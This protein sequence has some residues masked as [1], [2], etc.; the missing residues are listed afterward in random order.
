MPVVTED[1]TQP[2]PRD[3]RGDPDPVREPIPSDPPGQQSSQTAESAR[4][5]LDSMLAAPTLQ[6]TPTFRK[7]DR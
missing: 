6:P 2:R 1:E 4:H 3:E 7:E 5:P